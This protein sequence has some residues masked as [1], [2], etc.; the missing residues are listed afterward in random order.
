MPHAWTCALVAVLGCGAVL[1]PLAAQATTVDLTA[2][3][4]RKGVA[5]W[6][7]QAYHDAE[8]AA[9]ASG[10]KALDADG[11]LATRKARDATCLRQV[12][13][14]KVSG[15][16]LMQLVPLYLGASLDSFAVTAAEK[17]I[18]DA[19]P[20]AADQA[21]ALTKVIRLFAQADVPS[22]AAAEEFVSALDRLPDSALVAKMNA[23]SLLS[24]RY[25]DIGRVEEVQRH[26]HAIV[27]LG[28]RYLVPPPPTPG[29]SQ[30]GANA[31]LSAY[32]HL[33]EAFGDAGHA[34]SALIELDQ[35]AKDHPEITTGVV[36]A[37]LTWDREL[38]RLVGQRAFPIEADR[39]IN[40]GSRGRLVD[41]SGRVTLVEFTAHWCHPCSESYPSVKALVDRFADRPFQV[42]L[43]TQL[44]GRGGSGG[45][46]AESEVL[47]DRQFFV[48]QH[49]LSVP[50]AIVLPPSRTAAAAAP[51]NPNAV[52][53]HVNGI[54]EL[55][56]ID[57]SGVIRQIM[58]GWGPSSESHLQRVLTALTTEKQP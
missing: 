40:G 57:R 54:P 2:A 48:D 36:D 21:T 15:P 28:Y 11:L 56:V 45:L 43:A 14:A 17:I 41:P 8:L 37:A 31:I 18:R 35:A 34:D 6:Y 22:L 20:A 24:I 39:W 16:P 51:P 1:P 44:Y 50:I 49:G 25:D 30:V 3:V 23:H 32:A 13:L 58:I 7:G 33:A 42:L 10:A 27:A 38:Y 46:D 9:R 4:C 26:A 53:Y 29:A 5:D 19:P 55:I 12:D 52:H 47:F